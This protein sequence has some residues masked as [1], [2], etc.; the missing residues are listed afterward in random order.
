MT[1]SRKLKLL[2]WKNFVLKKRK[3][4]IT[5]LEILMPLLFSAL[6]LY[7]R[8]SSVPKPRPR[9]DYHPFDVTSLPEFFY[10]Y[11][12]KTKFQLV[13]IPSKSETLKAL[14]EMVEQTF[15]VE[16]EVL[17]FSS[18]PSFESYIIKDPRAFYA[19]VGIVLG[20]NF[21][22]SNEPLPLAVEYNLRFSYIQRNFLSLKH[23]YFQADLE[24]WCTSFLYPPYPSQ[25]PREFTYADGGTPGYHKEGFLAI[26]HA[27]DKAIMRHHAH[28]A[29]VTM[30]ES[31]S[32]LLQR[33]PY[34]PHI[35]DRFFMVLQNEFPLL[36]MLSFISIELIII[37]SITLEKEKKLKDYMCMMGLESWIHWIAWF[38]MFFISVLIAVTVMTILFCTKIK[39]VAVFR[40]SDPSLIFVFLTCFAIATIFFAFMMSTFFQKAHVGTAIGGTVFFFTY[41]PYL[42]LTFSYH[43]R[44]YSQKISFCL[45]S[46]VAMAMGIRFISR[47]E[48]EGTG[49]QWK[50]M[51]SITGEFSF[52]QVLLMLLLDS[53]LYCLITWY[54]EN[55]FPGNF[56]TSKPWYFFAL[57]SYWLGNHIPVTRPL[58]HLEDSKKTPGSQFMQEEPTDL[59]RGIEIHH[60]Y[61]VFH[62]GRNKYIAVRDLNMNMYRGQITVLL[63]HNGAGKST[64]CSMLTG[65]IIPSSGQAYIN[66][67]EISTDMVQIRK[68]MGWC[69][70]NDILFENF[71]VAE[72]LSFYAQLKGLSPQKCAEEVKQMLDTLSMKDKWSSRCKFLSGGMRRKLSIG[73]ALIAGSKLLILDEPTSGMDAISRRAIWD[74]LQQQ[75]SDR[76]ILLT[77][78]FMDEADLLGDRIAIMAKGEL[79]CCGSSLFLKQKYGAG[80]YM[81]LLK[82]PFC[83]TEKLC[84]L[85]YH[86]IPNAILES[87]VAEELI[88]ILPKEITHRY[89]SLFADLELQKV[90]LGISSFAASVTTMEEVFIRVCMLANC[91]SHRTTKEHH[92]RQPYPLI[93]RVPVDRIKELH[94][95]IF[96]IQTGLPIKLNTG[97][98]LFCQQFYAMLLKRVTYSWRNWMLMLS[99][100]I[101]VPLV[102]LVLTLMFFNFKT[103]S[104]ESVPLELTL[105]SY[106]QTIVPF[107]VSQ[108]FTLDPQLSNRFAD[109]LKAEGQ[110]P[111]QVSDPIE[112]FLLRK[113]KEEPENFD[114][115]YVVAASFE[116][117]DNDTIVTALFNNQAYH[118]PAVA[119]ALVDNL[120]FKLLSGASASITSFNYP[121]P[122]TE[123]EVSES[124]LYQGAKGYYLIIN[125]L[126]G[127]AFLSSSFSILTVRERRVKSKQVQFVSGVCITA[128]WFSALLWDLISF[129]IPTLLILVV[130]FYYNEEA[131][132]QHGN[133][134]AVVLV[135]ML[136]AWALIPFIYM[137]SFPFD[138]AGLGYTEISESL[139]H[140]FLILPGHCL[141]MA[142]FNLYHNFELKKFCSAKNLDDIECN[143]VSEGY[144]VQKNI[145]AWE[146]LGMG[147]YLTALAISGPLH[148]I[149]LFLVETNV[150][151][152]LKAKL[153]D[154]FRKQD[155]AMYLRPESEDQD[156]EEEVRTI[157][158]Y[159]ETLCKTNPL[160]VKEVSKVYD[161]K[162]PLLAVNKVSFTIQTKECFGLLGL[163][164]SGK[165][166]IFKMLTGQK[167][168]TS[169]DAFVKG[170]SISSQLGKV[171]QFIGYCPQFDALPNFMTGRE[172]LIMYARIRGI[173]ESH[174]NICVKQIIDDFV[175][176]MYADKLI[177]TYS[178]GNKR[179]L[180]IGIALI[181]EPAVIFL[182]EPSTGLDP[183]ARR[184]LWDTVARVRESGKAIVI[185]SH[186]MEECE[187]LCSRLAIMVQGQFKC[188]GSPQHLKNKFGGGYSLKAKF[189]SKGQQEA[190]E[191]FKAFMDLTFP[192]SILEDEHQGLVC[193]H[194]PG[195]NLIWSKVFGLMEKAKRKYKLE[196]YSINQVSLEDV[197]LGFIN[198]IGPT[199]RKD[200]E[201]A[202]SDNTSSFSLPLPLLPQ[203]SSPSSS[204]LSLFSPH[205]S[206][207]PLNPPSPSSSKIIPL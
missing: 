144:V 140:I 203:P 67:Y 183:V 64:T 48:A 89:E 182:D 112:E 155:L 9:T 204:H 161:V 168:T 33:F 180:S 80:Y 167:P 129:L 84:R 176:L 61:K 177:K 40:N 197:F 172:T 35:Q 173:P 100:Q 113:A 185:T 192:D 98:S 92:T 160:V 43:Q 162:V 17:G 42:Y 149:L 71:T 55:I 134:P 119:L 126:F 86:H 81:T 145:Y 18:V 56:Q 128:F 103:K 85:I 202:D 195:Y 97:F 206:Q 38:I 82:T 39:N 88:F 90:E 16:F 115:Q 96:S 174:I 65:L 157:K 132:T 25:E 34:G 95:R 76:T 175:M 32:V 60:L 188:L 196:D 27:V 124:L 123:E 166:S 47:F 31:L 94:S 118:S 199:Q 148:I 158:N 70:Q 135:L 93:S 41:L 13:Y 110:I 143:E 181:G 46:N 28:N 78:H 91:S 104:L 102:I 74:L 117:I 15:D 62:R 105:K 146:A 111:L 36:L 72:Q 37:N 116:V 30:F 169:G 179:K 69:P 21:S 170:F 107:F 163:N 66:G 200:Q 24:G 136:Y 108:N 194:L 8:F 23:V 57:P 120:L 7:L 45:F 142:F 141:G 153:Y 11:P 122:Q 54:M 178:G 201:Q 10:N 101:L 147:K 14:T 152:I 73:I 205:P 193:Y 130:F 165:T 44:S 154:F 99:V 133:A 26:Q 58:L 68:N 159:L 53:F 2:L 50:N 186:S 29:T 77:T 137:V 114:K 191:E 164:G 187:A 1:V 125:L 83:N 6:V 4:L 156:V 59:I 121:Q 79:Q 190:L 131:F 20:H 207:P 139:D 3:T 22:D 171:R 51:G 106:G 150:F 5:V 151:K 87:D 52:T 19:L 75:K 49:L 12:V 198:P 184:L 189:H 109:M 127:I 138:N 63:G